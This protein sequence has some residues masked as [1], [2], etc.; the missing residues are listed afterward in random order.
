MSYKNFTIETDDD[1]IALITW[2]MPEKS[3]NVIDLSVMDE[4][5]AI[6]DQ[7]AGD[8]A[9][10]GAIIQSG[11]A[12][13]SGGADL[14]MMEGLL[15][16]FHV[17]R[18]NDPEGAAKALYEGSRKLTL[19][20]RKL[21]TCGKP[22]VAAVCGTC[23]G[24]GTE[25]AL[26]C[27]AR[28][29]DEGLKMG[30]PEVKVGLFP[31]AGGTQRVMRM[32]DGQQGMQFLLQGRTLR[33]PQAK[34]MKLVDEVTG[35]K[36]LVAAARK[37]LNAGL[38]PVKDWD[39]KGYR[40]PNGKVYSPAGFQ[41]WPAANAI[42][43][44]ETH[45]NYPGAR[46]LL[47]AVVEGLQLPM[48]LA[49]QVESRYFAKVLQ[50]PEAANMIR[51]LFVSMQELNKLARR[52][53]GQR[54]NKIRKVGILGAGFM[55]AG[56]AYVSAKAGIDVVLIDREQEAADKG[57]AHS[58]ELMSKAI[59][60][61]RAS[62]E[63]KQKLLARI[64]P[65]VD[66]EALADCDLVIEAV[67]EDRD[68][69]KTV[70]EKAETVMKSRAIFASN[71]STLPITSLAQASKRP[72]NFIGIHFFSPV[73]KMML[74]EVILGKRTSDRALAM[75]LDYIKAIKKTP[76]VVN[77]SRGFYTSRVVMTYIREGLMMLADGVPAAMIENA[78]RMAGMPVGPLSLGDEVALDLAWK[79]V[80]ATR[81]DL[82][83]KYV[84][85]PLDNILEAMVV[86][87]ERFGRKNGKGFYDYKGKD[88]T[89]WPGITDVTGQPK[90]A[91]NFNIEELKQRLLVMQALETARIFEEK[92]LTDVR[93][94]DVGSILGFGFAPYTGGT[95]SYIDMMGTATFVDLCKK[96][97]RKW[98]PR[99]KPNKLLRD[100]ARENESFYGKF[101]PNPEQATKDAA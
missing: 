91:E 51:S 60:R 26:A 34:Q 1:G 17:K 85:G 35:T 92:C 24:G 63:Q 81:K 37:L 41:F 67:F 54:P 89:L 39:K 73:D 75:A 56:I 25:L 5:E 80:S 10:K 27:H 14:T 42:Y 57:K 16:D 3:M 11:K 36:K 21:E 100:M 87:Q 47:H 50:T 7:V 84:E 6:V 96:F 65:T 68:I 64:N 94:A 30:L 23:M 44:R 53:E 4:L 72:K 83:V 45:D 8:D 71:T 82:G 69:K 61:G 43:R 28:I 12:A 98:G 58:D 77:D 31:G 101:P 13:F 62:E 15:K 49:L 20:Y 79:I 48:D 93:E 66:Y 76:I 95:L 55:G 19:V 90:P 46:Y 88:K 22:F 18:G 38:D 74:V 40:L 86:K 70:T 29:V 59:K 9:I 97:T 33:A 2:D 99:F 52:P 32:T 78:G